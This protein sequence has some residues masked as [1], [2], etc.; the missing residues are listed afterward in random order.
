MDTSM[1][2]DSLAELYES[3]TSGGFKIYHELRGGMGGIELELQGSV[4]AKVSRV[5]TYIRISADRG[6]GALEIKF[7]GMTQWT[8]AG[9]W[10]A[11]LRNVPM[12]HQDLDQ[13][14]QYIQS[15]IHKMADDFLDTPHIESSLLRI[16]EEYMRK[17][18]GV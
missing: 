5:P 7:N 2:P 6:H 4:L 11:F 10:D 17:Q 15:N 3:L 16:E 12:E 9:V 18:L 14:T 13:Q 1:F 8:T